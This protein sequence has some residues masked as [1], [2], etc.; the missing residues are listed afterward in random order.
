MRMAANGIKVASALALG[1]ALASAV[2]FGAGKQ[3]PNVPDANEQLTPLIRSVDGSALFR[4]YCAPCHGVTGKGHGPAAPA[5]K[6][7]VPDLTLL[8]KNNGGSFPEAHVRR[9][10]M[11]DN[12]VMAHGS[13]EMPMWGPVFHQVQSDVDWGNVRLENLVKYL[14]TI[15]AITLSKPLSGAELYSQHCAV[16]HG[17]DLKGTG[18]AP[19]PFREPPDLT[20]VAR[21]HG[22]RFPDA[23]VASVLRSGV[24]MPAHG[25]AE[26]PVWGPDFTAAGLDRTEVALRI[27]RLTDYIKSQQAK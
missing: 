5:L 1:F 6:S 10:I 11:G 24:V 25:P 4:A 19:Y 20:T 2:L 26:M 13:R 23:Y 3:N 22:G 17:T 21:R 27:R 16:C 15:Q 7:K 9:V 18:P 8:S 12:A 14:E